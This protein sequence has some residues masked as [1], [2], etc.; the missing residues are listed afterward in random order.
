LSADLSP[1]ALG[2]RI[3]AALGAASGVKAVTLTPD[4]RKSTISV[5]VARYD[6]SL[7]QRWYAELAV[8][9]AAQLSMTTQTSLN[10]LI[11]HE[12]VT[13]PDA[14]GVMRTTDLGVGAAA[15]NQAFNSPSDDVL[16]KRVGEVARRFGLKVESV[17]VLHPLESALNVAFTV[18]DAAKMHWTIDDL[19]TAL[20]GTT[21][22]VEGALIQLNAE[23]G[24]S[25]LQAGG[26]YRTATGSLSFAPGQDT[27]FGAI[28]GMFVG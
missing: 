24:T 12:M 6:D 11:S 2:K 5:Q 18:P 20:V 27:R 16:T 28:H 4:G 17:Q 1:S 22:D 25:L 21:P 26:T 14:D 7:V 8:G 23:D 3:T 15:F 9:A 19:R 10:Q 13:G